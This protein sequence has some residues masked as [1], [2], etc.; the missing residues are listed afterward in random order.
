MKF[1][2]I[3]LH[4]FM[5]YKDD[6]ELMFSTDVK[7][8]VTVV[9]GNNTF[10]KTTLAQAFRWGLYEQFN[11][12][13]YTKKKD[14]V[15]LNN[16][17][18]AQMTTSSTQDAY[19]EIVLKHDDINDAE[20]MVE[21]NIDEIKF[22]RKALFT[23]KSDSAED[24]SIRQ[25][26]K[27]QLTMQMRKNGIWGDI[28]NND[29]SNKDRNLK[30]GCVQDVI[31]NM[32]P[33]KLSNYFFFDGERWNNQ[34]NKT[35]DIRESVNTILGVSSLIEMKKHLKDDRTNVISSL[36]KKV[37]G[38]GGESDRLKNDIASLDKKIAD[39]KQRICDLSDEYEITKQVFDNT[40]KDLMDN[41]KV[42]EENNQY[43]KLEKDIDCFQKVKDGHYA[44]I[45][46]EF[47]DSARFFTAS[48]LPEFK[49]VIEKVDL[50]GKDIPGV[51]IDTIDY[52]IENDECLCGTKL[53]ENKKAMETITNLRKL[54]PPEMLGGAIGKLQTTLEYWDQETSEIKEN[55]KNKAQLYN[56]DQNEIEDKMD[57][58]EKLGQKIDR[59]TNLAD[60]RR[61]NNDAKNK[62]EQLRNERSM[63]EYQ[64]EADKRTKEE[65]IAQLD[66]VARYNRANQTVYRA[67]SYA[68]A[69]YNIADRA[70]KSKTSTTLEDL[71]KIIADNFQRMFNDHEKY[72][73][74]GNDYQIHVYYRQVGNLMN[75]EEETLSNG[76]TIAINF[77]FI[78]SILELAKQYKEKEK[79][80]TEYGMQEAILGLPLVLDGPFSALSND[81]TKMLANRLPQ[82]AEQVIVFMLDKDWE[83]SGLENYTL[84]QYCYH[85]N[86]EDDANSSKLG[87]C[88]G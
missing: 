41:K 82:F 88:E 8:N 79:D 21:E 30:E 25:L 67:I 24:Y 44:D 11:D 5:R 74:L 42:E 17:V 16:E 12:T 78:V 23:R 75:Y 69:M 35:E 61:Q 64:I 37:Q 15:I 36:L 4:N 27:A 77:V 38:A 26:G 19:V 84:P 10:G 70:V 85:V 13:N 9:L 53:S 46:K 68:E 81:N 57:E 45:I 7:K 76:E 40:Y 62:M 58:M 59:K 18:I 49:A 50:S 56:T 65:K 1:K 48:L 66:A 63:L 29:G 33:P 72:A 22:V 83:A 71:N 32:F 14:I 39:S 20:D 55:I 54:V 34:K 43:K 87:L 73:K 47:S 86:K 51:T 6:N 60:V 52:L 2:S 28:V 80:N 31:N 3:K